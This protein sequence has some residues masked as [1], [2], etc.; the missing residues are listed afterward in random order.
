MYWPLYQIDIELLSLPLCLEFLKFVHLDASSQAMGVIVQWILISFN[1][2]HHE[3][4]S[5]IPQYFQYGIIDQHYLPNPY[6]IITIIF[7]SHHQTIQ[8]LTK[9]MSIH[10][11]DSC[12]W[13]ISMLLQ[14]PCN[15]YLFDHHL[16]YIFVISSRNDDYW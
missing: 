7:Y 13:H 1:T 3:Y 11:S 9:Y 4:W 16:V 2:N 12:A 10:S 5:A 14:W 6:Y 8:S 15:S